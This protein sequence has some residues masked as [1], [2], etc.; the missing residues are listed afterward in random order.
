[1]QSGVV[2]SQV[3]PTK[4]NEMRAINSSPVPLKW[5][6]AP[7]ESWSFDYMSRAVFRALGLVIEESHE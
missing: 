2:R 7:L 6:V 5:R 1:M 3:L 4:G